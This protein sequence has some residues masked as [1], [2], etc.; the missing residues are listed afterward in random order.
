M[1]KLKLQEVVIFQEHTANWETGVNPDLP[2]PKRTMQ[3]GTQKSHNSPHSIPETVKLENSITDSTC[4]V[5]GAIQALTNSNSIHL[6]HCHEKGAYLYSGE[7]WGTGRRVSLPKSTQQLVELGHVACA[8]FPNPGAKK[9]SPNYSSL[10]R[11]TLPS[12]SF[13][14]ESTANFRLPHPTLGGV[15]DLLWNCFVK[16]L[17]VQGY[18]WLDHHL[19]FSPL[20]RTKSSTRFISRQ[21]L[22]VV[23]V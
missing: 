18:I 3:K 16:L 9:L 11:C 8:V 7:N 17:I 12:S 2:D 1:R 10:D 19:E 15:G 5:L 23:F 4:Y 21:R 13:F 6:L 14:W 20:Q 22:T